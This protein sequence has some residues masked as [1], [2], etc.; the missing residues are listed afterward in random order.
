MK[1]S[2]YNEGP[3]AKEKFDEAMKTLFR[4]PKPKKAAPKAPTVR[5]SKPDDK[6]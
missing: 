3:E 5:K 6:D 4:A 2:E 1:Q